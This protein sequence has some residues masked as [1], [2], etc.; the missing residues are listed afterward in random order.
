MKVDLDKTQIKD[1]WSYPTKAGKFLHM[2]NFIYEN[3]C[4]VLAEEAEIHSTFSRSVLGKLQSTCIF[5]YLYIFC[6]MVM[7]WI[8]ASRGSTRVWNVC[9][10]Y[11]SL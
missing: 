10:Y 2:F 5:R 1:T 11:F 9:K 3:L 6:G 4:Y 8:V 7:R